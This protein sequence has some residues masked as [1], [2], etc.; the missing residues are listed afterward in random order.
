MKLGVV[1]SRTF[2]NYD[3]L[4]K[5]LSFH[6]DN[7]SLIISGGCRGADLLAIDYAK[8]HRIKYIEFTANWDMEGRSAGYNRNKKIVEASD[9][10]IAFWDGKSKGTK[11]TID[12]AESVGKLVYIYWPST[13]EI[14][15]NIGL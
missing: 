7:I 8:E 15:E 14:I 6:S 12:L 5:C 2:N 3:F 11:H 4:K 13:N 10:I 1:G 9:E